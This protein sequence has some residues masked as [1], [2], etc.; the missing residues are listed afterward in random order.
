MNS[1]QHTIA[2][3]LRRP[4]TLVALAAAVAV[5]LVFVAQSPA[6]SFQGPVEVTR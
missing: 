6:G 3:I 4:A 5:S 1:S 2:I